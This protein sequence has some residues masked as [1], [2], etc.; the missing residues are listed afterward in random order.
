MKQTAEL[1][2]EIRTCKNCAFRDGCQ[3]LYRDEV[4]GEHR[5]DWESEDDDLTEAEKKSIIGD[6]QYQRFKEDDF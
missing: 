1:P 5:F 2:E 4:C 6:Y 3:S